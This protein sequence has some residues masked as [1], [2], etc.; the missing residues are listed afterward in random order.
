MSIQYNKEIFS[1]DT[2]ILQIN[3]TGIKNDITTIDSLQMSFSAYYKIS[4][5]PIF[6][7]T[8]NFDQIISLYQHLNQISIINNPRKFKSSKFIETTDQIQSILDSLSGNNFDTLKS[9]IQFINKNSDEQDDIV[10]ILLESLEELSLE[11]LPAAFK[12][13]KYKQ[14]F[15]NL[16]LLLELEKEGNILSA[17]KKIPNLKNYIA[18]QPEAI[19][20][21]WI[22]RNIQ[23]IFGVEYKT[24]KAKIRE[25]ALDCK[26]DVV[27]ES[28]D[29][30]IDLIEL[31]RPNYQILNLDTSHQSYYPTAALSKALGQCGHY[32]KE[33]DKLKLQL[34][35]KH[36]VK[37]LRPRI[38]IIIGRTNEFN[39]EQYEALRMLNCN[40]NNIQIIS[41]DYL[42]SCGQHILSNLS[43]K[44]EP[45]YV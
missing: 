7:E 14:E 8:F 27:V 24:H 18:G 19:F 5:E 26:A 41:Y 6:A 12:Y 10:E 31:K 45:S 13:K 43:E 4:G 35:D 1:N 44:N 40:L 30:F 36:K 34:Q 3:F 20:Q 17:I 15:D 22:E 28:M 38:K 25:I 33:M 39:E 32:L 11:D 42:L 29:G 21:E 2:L 9:I 37:V 23:W 16:E